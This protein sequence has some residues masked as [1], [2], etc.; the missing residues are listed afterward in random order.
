M[1]I[2]YG[3]MLKLSSSNPREG[4]GVVPIVQVTMGVLAGNPLKLPEPF[5][6]AATAIICIICTAQIRN[7]KESITI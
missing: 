1:M 6:L 3:I 2:A 7:A 5:A 4:V